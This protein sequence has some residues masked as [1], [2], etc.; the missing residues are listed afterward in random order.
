MSEERNSNPDDFMPVDPESSP[1]PINIDELLE[2]DPTK[3][4]ELVSTPIGPDG[5][6]EDLL[7]TIRKLKLGDPSRNPSL[8]ATFLD[9]DGKSW[10]IV[11]LA[12][13]YRGD[14]SKNPRLVAL[15]VADDGTTDFAVTTLREIQQG[16]PGRNPRLVGSVPMGEMVKYAA[17]Q[18]EEAD[19]S[20]AL[21]PVKP[22]SDSSYIAEKESREQQARE[23]AFREQQTREQA[24]REQQAREQAFREQQTREQALRE[25]RQREQRE[26]EQA[27]REQRQREQQEQEQ[28]LREQ[29]QQEEALRLQQQ[30]EQQARE[31][32]LREQRQREQQEQEQALRSRQQDALR[33]A[34]DIREQDSILEPLQELFSDFRVVTND[35][36]ITGGSESLIT[37]PQLPVGVSIGYFHAASFPLARQYHAAIIISN[38][39]TGESYAFRAGPQVIAEQPDI[40]SIIIPSSGLKLPIHAES[41]PFNKDF[42]DSTIEIIG[43]Q[44]VG[45]LQINYDEAINRGKAFVERVNQAQISYF[46]IFDGPNSNTFAFRL[47]EELGFT[48]PVPIF[49]LQAWDGVLPVE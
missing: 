41:G 5:N 33:R 2:G 22:V 4:P 15:F 11:N 27:L 49:P 17:Y 42:A 28:A 46:P 20:Q 24:L 12:E 13:L 45:T 1:P 10:Q 34:Q 23:Q 19:D 31:Q 30:R 32:A 16:D 47:L 8:V 38:L 7:Q 21:D 26:Q 44:R 3:N 6:T 9:P 48:R 18:E 35:S 43:V 14:P 25:Q 37:N 36:T 29:G 39:A 40:I